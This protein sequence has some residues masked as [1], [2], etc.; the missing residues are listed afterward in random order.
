MTTEH[1]VKFLLPGTLFPEETRVQLESRSTREAMAFADKNA[2]AFKLYDVEV[3]TGVL[4]DGEK[5]ENRRM[6]NE[7]GMY[8]IG[9]KLLDKEDIAKEN[10]LNNRYS[11]LLSNM[12]SNGYE[13]VVR[14]RTGNYQPFQEGDVLFAVPKREG[15]QGQ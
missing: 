12:E 3:R 6:V 14:C 1:W 7:S 4:E 5:I 8:F 9:G 15:G 13:Y 2:Y 10:E 11:I